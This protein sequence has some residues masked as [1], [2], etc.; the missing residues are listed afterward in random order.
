[1]HLFD[2]TMSVM[3][4]IFQKSLSVFI[5]HRRV[6]YDPVTLVFFL[7]LIRGLNYAGKGFT[8]E[9]FEIHFSSSTHYH[10]VS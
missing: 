6:D 7:Y 1:M 9:L 3:L 10:G 2:T 4:T 8:N 5:V